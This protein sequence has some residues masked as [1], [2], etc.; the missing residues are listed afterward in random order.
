M[1]TGARP[2]EKIDGRDGSGNQVSASSTG[3]VTEPLLNFAEGSEMDHHVP[4]TIQMPCKLSLVKKQSVY[5]LLLIS[6]LSACIGISR[7]FINSL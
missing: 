7:V 3:L 5:T 6:K 1:Q 4:S 2:K